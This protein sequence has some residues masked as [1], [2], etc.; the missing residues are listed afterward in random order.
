MIRIHG[1]DGPTVN[2]GKNGPTAPVTVKATA[3]ETLDQIRTRFASMIWTRSEKN[4]QEQR[5]TFKRKKAH[6]QGT[7]LC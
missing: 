6:P 4:K 1:K 3:R 7:L 2:H 5:D